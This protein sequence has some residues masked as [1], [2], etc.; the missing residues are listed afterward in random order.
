MARKPPKG[1]LS[2]HFLR[3]GFI[4]QEGLG[5]E[6]CCT[7]GQQQVVVDGFVCLFGGW[8]RVSKVGLVGMNGGM[9]RGRSDPDLALTDKHPPKTK[10]REFQN[11]RP[12]AKRNRKRNNKQIK[13]I[14]AMF[15]RYSGMTK[16]LKTIFS[17]FSS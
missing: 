7:V 10:Q 15:S 8:P 2:V 6:E 5:L 1:H 11:S 4:R 17:I 12:Q 14:V 13:I 3:G 16:G 9:G